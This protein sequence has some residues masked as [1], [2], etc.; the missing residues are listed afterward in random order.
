MKSRA[1]RCAPRGAVVDA[2]GPIGDALDPSQP[3]NVSLV[4]RGQ[5]GFEEVVRHIARSLGGAHLSLWAWL[6]EPRELDGLIAAYRLGELLSGRLVVESK[7]PSTY[8]WLEAFGP[9]SVLVAK[10]HS[11]IAR[12]WNGSRRVL[13]RG[14]CCI[15]GFPLIEQLDVTE[16]GAEFA[17]V[18]EVEASFPAL[19]EPAAVA[20]AGKAYDVGGLSLFGGVSTWAK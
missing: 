17:L 5:F 15:T 19:D 8:E 2:H 18:E 16:G 10:S 1:A 6:D 11:K 4:T 13:V 7:K 3:M 20:R 9:G 14:S 12:M